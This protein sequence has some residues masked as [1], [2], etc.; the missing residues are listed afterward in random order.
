LAHIHQ[1]NHW[2]MPMSFAHLFLRHLFFF[3]RCAALRRRRVP[4][5]LDA[6][7]FGLAAGAATLHM[8]SADGGKAAVICLNCDLCDFYDYHERQ[9]VRLKSQKSN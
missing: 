1:L 2:F 9:T 6:W 8:P 5:A 3:G 7:P 4:R